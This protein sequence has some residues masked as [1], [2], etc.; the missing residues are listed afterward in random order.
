M[1]FIRRAEKVFL[2]FSH[3]DEKSCPKWELC[4]MHSKITLFSHFIALI[5]NKHRITNMFIYT[6]H[7]CRV[8]QQIFYFYSIIKSC[9][10]S[11]CCRHIFSLSFWFP[12]WRT[13]EIIIRRY[14]HKCRKK[15]KAHIKRDTQHRNLD[16]CFCIFLRAC[17]SAYG[18]LG[19]E[20]L[21]M[22]N[23]SNA[24]SGVAQRCRD[25]MTTQYLS[26]YSYYLMVGPKYHF[27]LL[28]RIF[29]HLTQF[30]V[31]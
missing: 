22:F 11:K 30:E 16:S 23:I 15:P 2:M 13:F 5:E 20:A 7:N 6:I 29:D 10:T 9:H 31:I 19:T 12:N 27:D 25:V 8:K 14:I 3:C 17:E 1:G 24:Y 21:V 18:L 28:D 4:S 26:N